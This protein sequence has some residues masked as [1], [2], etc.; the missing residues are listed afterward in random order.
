MM[1]G[2]MKLLKFCTTSS[3]TVTIETL[4]RCGQ[5]TC[6]K[7]CQGLAPSTCAARSRVSGT[8]CRPAISMI[9]AKENS[10]HTFTTISA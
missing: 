8:V 2:M 10:F 4:C 5:V 9:M 1:N 3:S 6:Q 7:R